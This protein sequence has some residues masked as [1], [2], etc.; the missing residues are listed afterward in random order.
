MPGTLLATLFASLFSWLNPLSAILGKIGEWETRLL[1][2]KTEQERIAA[3]ERIAALSAQASVAGHPV[4]AIMRALMAAPGVAFV[5]KLVVYDKMLG[6]GSTE[7]LSANLW[8][9][10][11]A[12][13]WGFYFLHWTVGRLR[14]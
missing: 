8:Y 4:D 13:P 14:S 7:D 9:F 10:A 5:W 1:D 3:G 2:A 6:W 12:L 11:I